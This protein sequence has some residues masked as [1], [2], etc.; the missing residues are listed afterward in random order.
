MIS[1]RMEQCPTK[2]N[3]LIQSPPTI[4]SVEF[5]TQLSLTIESAVDQLR[6]RRGRGSEIEKL[7]CILTIDAYSIYFQREN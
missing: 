4:R 3:C 5:P 6:R 7:V 1:Y 2:T